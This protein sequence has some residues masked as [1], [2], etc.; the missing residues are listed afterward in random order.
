MIFAGSKS[1]ADNFRVTIE[2]A[3]TSIIENIREFDNR[4]FFW[5]QNSCSFVVAKVSWDSM[6]YMNAVEFVIGK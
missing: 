6:S 1:A 2:A 4:S 5:H 3:F